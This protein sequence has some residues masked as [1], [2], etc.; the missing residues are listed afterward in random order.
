MDNELKPTKK[1]RHFLYNLFNPQ[2]KGIGVEKAPEGPDNI[3]KCFK[4]LGRN[5]SNIFYMN[6]MFIF[7]NF[8]LTFAF[9]GFYFMNTTTAASSSLFGPVSGA[10]QFDPSPVNA[11]L[12]GVHG[13][14][15]T[16]NVPSEK[17]YVFWILTAL[18]IFTF[19]LVSVGLTYLMRAIV[20]GQHFSLFSDFLYAIKKNWKQGLIMG[21]IDCILTAVCV[22]AIAFYYAIG[23]QLFLVSIIV[24]C[25]YLMMRNYFYLML[26]T[27]DLSI[28]KIIKNSLIFTLLGFKRNILAFIGALLVVGLEILIFGIFIPLGIIFPFIFLF[29]LPMFFGVY[30]AYP[31]IK[32]IMIDPQLQ[33]AE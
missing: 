25:F 10:L 3:S 8:P 17:S 13:A 5:I 19:G 23:S 29:S 14:Q 30:A 2:G 33:D 12:F 24:L 16:T 20:R 31:K 11:A 32:E 15:V 22:Y 28:W 21:I 7:G 4:L 9:L 6:L 18:L 1:K 26:I 27:F